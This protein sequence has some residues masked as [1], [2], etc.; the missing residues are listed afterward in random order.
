MTTRERLAEAAPGLRPIAERVLALDSRIDVV[1]LDADG[2]AHS[3]LEVAA[4]ED[5][6]CAIARS[7]ACARWLDLHLSDWLQIA[8]DLDAD[9]EAGVRAALLVEPQQLGGE[10]SLALAALGPETLTVLEARPEC[11]AAA[12]PA[13]GLA[14]PGRATRE[15]PAS[16]AAPPS[17]LA[18]APRRSGVAAPGRPRFR[19]GLRAEDL[20]PAAPAAPAASPPSGPGP[21]RPSQPA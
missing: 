12:A 11:G 4:D 6:L 21:R 3:I 5:P 14:A 13:S 1:A 10:A 7:L 17:S 15:A 9:P 19:T 8:P 20:R 18:A 2:R 16:Q